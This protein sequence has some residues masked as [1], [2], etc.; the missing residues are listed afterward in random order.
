MTL[1]AQRLEMIRANAQ[2]VVAQLGPLSEMV[3]G[4]DQASVAWVEGFIERQR[5]NPESDESGKA[6]LGS[7]IACYVGEA[8]IAATGGAWDETENGALGVRFA[9]GNWCFPFAKVSKQLESG[10]EAG[11][12]VLSFYNVSVTVLA[13]GESTLQDE[14]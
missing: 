9:N 8:I 4:Y 1:D 12:S 10:L 5:D 14:T 7:V 13:R 2:L 3:F 11:E 6:R